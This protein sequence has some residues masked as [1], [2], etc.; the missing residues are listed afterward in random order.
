[1]VHINIFYFSYTRY[2]PGDMLSFKKNI[3]T[4]F[5]YLNLE[6]TKPDCYME[7][8]VESLIEK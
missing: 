1:M 2:F 3:L 6:Y 7:S 8:P 4:L 5:H